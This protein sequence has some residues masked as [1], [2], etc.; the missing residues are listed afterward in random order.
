MN[1]K[2]E[3]LI[4]LDKKG[5]YCI[6]NIINNKVYI[7]STWVSFL[8]RFKKHFYNFEKNNHP[9]DKLKNSIL[10]YGIDNFEFSIL[11]IIEDKNLLLEKEKQ[12]ID[13]Y[14]NKIEI[15]NLNF[16]PR[17]SPMLND[18]IKKKVGDKIK[19]NYKVGKQK[20]NNSVFKKGSKP[21]NK[22]KKYESTDHLKVPKT[23][24]ELY[25][26][27]REKFKQTTRS[28]S[29]IIDVYNIK[30]NYLQSFMSAKDLEEWSLTDDNNLPIK[31]R[32]SIKRND[33]PLKCLQS[34]NINKAC[35]TGKAYKNLFFKYRSEL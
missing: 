27:G 15:Y 6:T 28:K 31:S 19:Q 21:W 29:P 23:K 26:K 7:G 5:I 22:D 16:D 1:I 3:D 33:I 25:Y 20:I 30:G 17:F 24:T 12:W 18:E 35:K 14:R 13:Y 32:F 8:K 9:N 11:E 34:S 10:K 2:K 4:N